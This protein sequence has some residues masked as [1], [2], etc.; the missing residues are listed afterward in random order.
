MRVLP[1]RS[2]P[3]SLADPLVIRPDR[4]PDRRHRTETERGL[5]GTHHSDGGSRL[6]K[7]PP[8][9]CITR[10]GGR[11]DNAPAWPHRYNADTA[12]YSTYRWGS[13]RYQLKVSFVF[14]GGVSLK[15]LFTFGG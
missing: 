5:H 1:R 2:R 4:Q 9:A 8:T 14:G 15:V 11:V 6:R 10:L 12:R 3:R 7:D 13:V